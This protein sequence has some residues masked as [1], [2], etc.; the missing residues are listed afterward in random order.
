MKEVQAHNSDYININIEIQL[1][2]KQSNNKIKKPR[3]EP[4]DM[5]FMVLKKLR[6]I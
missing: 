3:I 6:L 1:A 2:E 5:V 4:N